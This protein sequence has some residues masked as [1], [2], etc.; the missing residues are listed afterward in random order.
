LTLEAWKN[1]SPSVKRILTIV[2]FFLFSTMIAVAGVLT[3]LSPEE[4]QTRSEDLKQLQDEIRGLDVWDM[5]VYIFANNFR[6][7]LM[8]F[9]PLAGP[10]IGTY[11]LYNTGVFIGAE[12]TTMNVPGLLILFSL[13]LFPFTWMEFIAYAIGLSGSVWLT[14]CIVRRKW[15]SEIKMTAILIIICAVMLFVAALIEALLIASY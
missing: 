5:K 8:M 3:P 6:I 12:S 10:F 15:K 9:I 1:T 14:W 7:C 4:S 2:V 11:V 13:F